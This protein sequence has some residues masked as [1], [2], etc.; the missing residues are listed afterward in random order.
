MGCTRLRCATQSNTQKVEDFL[1]GRFDHFRRK[2][3]IFG[4][5]EIFGKQISGIHPLTPFRCSRVHG[6]T[7]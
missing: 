2:I 1:L 6:L 3:F 4:I 5:N 7:R